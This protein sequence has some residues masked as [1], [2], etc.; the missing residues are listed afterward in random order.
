VRQT[1]R[2]GAADGI[3]TREASRYRGSPS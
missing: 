2:E 3:R 1:A